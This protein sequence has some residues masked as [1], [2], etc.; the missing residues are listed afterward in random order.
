V[1][2]NLLESST[3]M[4]HPIYEYDQGEGGY[5]DYI[6]SFPLGKGLNSK[7]IQ[8]RQPLLLGTLEEQLANGAYATPEQLEQ[9]SGVTTQ[10]WLGVPILINDQVLGTVNIS[11]YREHAYNE[12]HLRLLQTLASN[13]GVAIENARLFEAEQQR[14]AELQ[15]INSIQQGLAAE[16]DF[17]AIVDLVGDKLREVFQTPDLGISWYDEKTKLLHYLYN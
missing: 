8:T 1:S 7:V 14:I 15:I 5:L 3:E 16:L 10:S 12:S 4:I 13:M 2:I 11:H 9:D 6:Q 17:Q